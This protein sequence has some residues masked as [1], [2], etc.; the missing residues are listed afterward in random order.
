M[1]KP[2]I[3]TNEAARIAA[4]REYSVLDTLPEKDFDD[5]T[6]IASQICGTPISLITLVDSG[7]QWFKSRVG[8]DT[9]ETP[10]DLAFCAHAINK[11]HEMMV[12]P[13]SREDERFADNPLVTGAPEVIFYAGVPL[14]NPDGFALGTLCIID[15]KPKE[16]NEQQKT[17]LKS[18]SSYVVNLLELR[19]KNLALA[20][21]KYEL[22]RTLELYTQSKKI[23]RVGGWEMDVLRNKITWTDMTREIHEVPEDFVPSLETGLRAYKK[24]KSRD[25]I[26]KLVKE[27]MEKGTPYDAELEMITY[28]GKEIWVRIKGEAEFVNGKC[29][30][31]F[32]I[33]Q[34]I[35]ETKIKDMLLEQSEEQFRQTFNYASIG[36]ALLTLEGKWIK[37]NDALCRMVGYTEQELLKMSF[38]E[39]TPDED[40]IEELW[41][42]D[43]LLSGEKQS[44]ELEKRY[45]HKEGHIVWITR[46]V[47]VV[48]DQKNN[49][50]HLV[51]QVMDITARKEAEHII[52]EERR[53]LRTL[54]DNIPVN[55]FIKDLQS[56]KI[57]V[58][59]KEM[60]YTGAASEEEVLGKNDFELYPPETAAV[61]IAEDIEIFETGKGM[62]D[63]ET[64]NEKSDGS[65]NWF[66]TSK[67]PLKD[68][69]DKITGL[70]GISHGINERKENER[71]M[72]LLM[73]VTAEQNKRLLNFAHIVSHNL[74]S[75]SSNFS[76]LLEFMEK[77]NDPEEKQK[78]FDLLKTASASLAETVS[79][80]NEV[81]AVNTNINEETETVN[82]HH[83]I[84]KV[85]DNIKG[86]LLE[87]N[88]QCINE[89]DPS[90]NIKAV[91]AYLDSILL[92]FFTNSL[93]YKSPERAPVITLTS[94][95]EN[96][97]I[98]L[99]FKDNGIGIDLK[100]HKDKLFGMY[101]TF[102]GNK[103]ARGVGLFITK[104]QI[105]A[106]GGK[107][108]A[109]SVPGE[110]TT[111]IISFYEKT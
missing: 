65:K 5:I 9:P 50:L 67:I 72:K 31:L 20:A 76:M 61:S 102:H 85:Q 35:H 66:L 59:R 43:K 34:D 47:S 28:K 21:T 3:A 2:E 56:R 74:R 57:L 25:T 16:L 15:N 68:E 71:K 82:L 23:A 79:N 7:R 48:K 109:E 105:E 97:F 69:N 92:N 42:L 83:A 26:T 87:K 54:I 46:T 63:V 104:N 55:I 98:I 4:L 58:N 89:V 49:P 40:L 53:L 8:L 38:H 13:D 93:K 19:R 78:M 29:V 17:A 64:M 100:K 11:P 108:E 6:L 30:R 111:F 41:L 107:I 36:M 73:D 77:E 45:I 60:E 91:P 62:F 101:N 103:D 84:E 96:N 18:L 75:H 14:I 44:Y 70:L 86:L 27:A 106:M 22:R 33:F 39:I 94:E 51:S 12:I 1:I 52:K 37:V 24:G 10:R 90:F 80:L 95:K 110:G 99:T 81:V 32:G 88:A